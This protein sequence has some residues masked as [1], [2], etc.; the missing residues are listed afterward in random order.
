MRSAIVLLGDLLTKHNPGMDRPKSK[1]LNY[2][3]VVKEGLEDGLSW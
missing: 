2:I 1:V 3:R